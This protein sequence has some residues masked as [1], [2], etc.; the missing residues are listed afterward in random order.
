MPS[1]FIGALRCPKCGNDIAKGG[2]IR[3]VETIEAAR[4]IR[5]VK[6]SF[7]IDRRY[8]H[9]HRWLRCHCRSGNCQQGR[10]D[11]PQK[12]NVRS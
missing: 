3:Y 12:K 11:E 9:R 8:I 1:E 4:R 6:N 5:R 10:E 7:T 2:E